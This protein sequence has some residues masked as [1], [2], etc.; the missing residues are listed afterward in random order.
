MPVIVKKYIVST[1]GLLLVALGVALS[2]ISNLGTAALSCPAYI[3]SLH[4]KPTV[5][6]FTIMVNSSLILF[7]ILLLRKRYKAKYLMQIPASFV[8]GYMIDLWMW[9]LGAVAP[10]TYV[11]RIALVV[12]GCAVTALGTSLEVAAQAWML[13]C[14][15][16]VYCLTKVS[17]KPFGVLKI[18]MDCSFVAIAALL[19]FIFFRNPFGAGEFTSLPDVLL[20]RTPGVMIGLGTLIS[21][22][23]IGFFMRWTDP[24]VDKMMAGLRL[25]EAETKWE[26][27]MKQ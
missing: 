5:G 7:Q 15:M 4:W 18:F 27:T 3:L 13:S 14:E 21:A 19:S 10:T 11:A 17:V 16:T 9:I 1:I 23:L 2:I 20:A 8:F 26:R 6:E 25:T 22:F 24:P 12:G